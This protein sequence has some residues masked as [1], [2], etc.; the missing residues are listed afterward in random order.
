MTGENADEA[1]GWLLSAIAYG[2][3]RRN[4]PVRLDANTLELPAAPESVKAARDFAASRLRAWGLG[5]MCEDVELVVSELVTN[6]L[7]YASVPPGD[8]AWETPFRLSLLRS[9]G[10]LTCAVTDPSD[11]VPVRRKPD[12]VSQT[13]RGLHLVEAFSDSWNWM[14][15]RDRGKIVWACFQI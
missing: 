13:G 4:L 6:A 15:L 12:F 10:R 9:G 11:E 8:V 5:P 1:H 14:S 7:R 3:Q 2:V